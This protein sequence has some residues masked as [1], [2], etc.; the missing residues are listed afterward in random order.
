MLK[1][2]APKIVSSISQAIGYQIFITDEK[3]ILVGASDH[4]IIGTFSESALKSIKCR[5]NEPIKYIKESNEIK[6]IIL[7]VKLAGKI[8]GTIGI[9]GDPQEVQ[10]F[11]ILAKN[12]AESLLWEEVF[13]NSTLL[14]E[15]AVKSFIKEISIFNES[16]TEE[17]VIIAK[18]YK[19]GFDITPPHIAIAI[20]VC[21]EN[22]LSKVKDIE[23]FMHEDNEQYKQGV[24][25]EI[26]SK[27]KKIFSGID[28]IVAPIGVNRYIILKA[29]K[30]SC[31]EK[32]TLEIIEDTCRNFS[33]NLQEGGI[34]VYIGIGSL[35]RNVSGLSK[36]YK[37]SWRAI[38]IGKRAKKSSRIFQINEFHLESLILNTQKD[39]CEDFLQIALS[40]LKE[41]T[42]WI[43]LSKTIK[44]W[45]ECR[46]S[47]VEAAKELF[48]HR[49]TL[50]HRLNKIY[51]VSGINI[52]DFKEAIT[53]YLAVIMGEIL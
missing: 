39:A 5:K 40:T 19:L 42:D 38:E 47:Q 18:G 34:D 11:G 7:T 21:K 33:R 50:N 46:F 43:D 26:I 41:Q 15:E 22:K 8:V 53:L 10:R 48:I 4:S 28:D 2:L 52:K 14:Q 9:T 37:E 51:K 3:A 24:K 44:A 25:I 30:C 6:G 17:F 1:R 12:Q 35:A 27:I 32:G 13:Y 29:L 36:S 16:K 20:E 31:D 49:N 45:C 23:G